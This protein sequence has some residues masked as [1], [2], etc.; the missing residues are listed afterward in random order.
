MNE[1]REKGRF[2]INIKNTMAM[3]V[4]MSPLIANLS[5]V[6]FHAATVHHVYRGTNFDIATNDL[7][8]V[9]IKSPIKEVAVSA[10][11]DAGSFRLFNGHKFILSTPSS[12]TIDPGQYAEHK[13]ETVFSNARTW[14]I[15]G[16]SHQSNH[17]HIYIQSELPIQVLR[18]LDYGHLFLHFSMAIVFGLAL[19][20][21][22][23]TT[24][25]RNIFNNEI[26]N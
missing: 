6:S 2:W 14:R 10:K 21:F 23:A 20:F 3:I 16:Y 11:G 18:R 4:L 19:S 8:L 15:I 7:G 13:T 12:T 1:L 17:V 26:F 24:S 22:L 9:L 25:L 5:L